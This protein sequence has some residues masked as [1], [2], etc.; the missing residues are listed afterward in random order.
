MNLCLSMLDEDF[1]NPFPIDLTYPQSLD[2][3]QTLCVNITIVD[4][5]VL[6]NEEEFTVSI[7]STDNNV[8]TGSPSTVIITDNDG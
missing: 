4:D 6:E 1:I 5:I 7:E 8:T 3:S 2:Q